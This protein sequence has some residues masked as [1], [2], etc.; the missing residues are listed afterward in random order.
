[1]GREQGQHVGYIRVSTLDQNTERQLDGI[2]LAKVFTDKASGKD[3][4]RPALQ[5][6]LNY[7]REG[8]TL[9]VHSMVWPENPL[10]R[11]GRDSIRTDASLASSRISSLASNC[12]A[13]RQSAA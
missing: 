7:L 9:M 12:S 5:A 1:M 10:S 11:G 2:E 8:D 3:A 13:A 6:T 4:K